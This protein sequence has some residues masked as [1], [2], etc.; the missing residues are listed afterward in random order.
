MRRFFFV[1]GEAE[2]GGLSRSRAVE[3]TERSVANDLVF[4][5]RR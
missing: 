3:D 4:S 2:I 1:L 5:R